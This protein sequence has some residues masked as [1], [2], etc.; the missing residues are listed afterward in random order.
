MA[1]TYPS[2]QLPIERHPWEPWI[3]DNAKVLIMGTFPPGEHRRAMEFYYPNRTNDFWRV[4][5]IIFRDDAEAFYDRASRS[6][7]LDDIK[8]MLTLHGIALS[9][10][11]AAVRRLKGNAS[12]KYL[13]IVEAAPVAEL[14]ARMPGCTAIATTGEKAAM[15]LAEATSTEAPAMGK[16]IQYSPAGH[17]DVEIWR[18]PST[19]R[20]YPLAPER[21]ADYYREFFKAAYIL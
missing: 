13:E 5:G 9:D 15:T 14:L 11:G 6:Y 1:D 16:H 10:T 8:E 20:A 3:P 21:K 2:E 18:L 17:Q 4:M 19:S 12:D 7:R